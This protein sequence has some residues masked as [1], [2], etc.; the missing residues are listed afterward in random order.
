MSL[1]SCLGYLAPS[2]SG[3]LRRSSLSGTVGGEMVYHTGI[4]MERCVR[5]H[6]GIG[7]ATVRKR[8]IHTVAGSPS[9]AKVAS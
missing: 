3:S 2:V 1:N 5:T 4:I 9:R 6:V 7:H 8:S